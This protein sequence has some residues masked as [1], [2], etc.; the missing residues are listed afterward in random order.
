EIEKASKEILNLFLTVLDEGYFTDG[1]GH[2]VDCKN[3]IIIGTSNAGSDFIYKQMQSGL[4]F[5][6]D[7]AL[8]DYLIEQKLFSPEF[9]NRF[10]AVIAYNPLDVQSII[11]VAKKFVTI[12]ADDMY[13]LHKI[14]L[15]VPDD[16]LVE[17]AKIGYNEKFGARD[18]ERLL[19][20]HIEDKVAKLILEN[21]VKQGETIQ[22]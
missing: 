8:V 18:M 9:L 5:E 15:A 14:K 17:L 2:R 4:H 21:K 1:F 12:I 11:D 19:R 22:L 20:T 3:L 16:R 6:N 10:D 7:R 13:K